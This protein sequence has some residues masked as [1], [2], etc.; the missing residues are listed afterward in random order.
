MAIIEDVISASDI[1]AMLTTGR[2]NFAIFHN[3]IKELRRLRHGEHPVRIPELYANTQGAIRNSIPWVTA[4][5]ITASLTA[6]FPSIHFEPVDIGDTHQS[7]ASKKERWTDAVLKRLQKEAGEKIFTQIMDNA[8]NDGLGIAK[9]TYMPSHWIG[10]AQA[11]TADGKFE[12]GKQDGNEVKITR[13][14]A[15]KL[16]KDGKEAKR[17]SKLP[18]SWRS[19]DPLNY[20]P[21]Y[22]EDGLAI[23]IEVTQ[24]PRMMMHK[25][26]R[27]DRRDED[28]PTGWAFTELQKPVDGEGPHADATVELIEFWTREFVAYLCDG[29]MRI[30][31]NPQERPPYFEIPGMMSAD[32]RPHRKYM[33]S[34]NGMRDIAPALDALLTMHKNLSYLQAYPKMVKTKALGAREE[35]AEVPI[36]GEEE[37]SDTDVRWI[38]GQVLDLSDEPGT[39]IS[40]RVPPDSPPLLEEIRQLQQMMRD[41]SPAE[42]FFGRSSGADEAGVAIS[43]RL[44]QSKLPLNWIATN[45]SEGISEM[46]EHMLWSLE[47]NVDDEVEVWGKGISKRGKNRDDLIS[48]GPKDVRGF[49]AN[50]VEMAPTMP[51]EQITEGQYA[52]GMR[53]AGLM[54]QRQALETR[55][56]KHPDETKRELMLEE[57]QNN[58]VVKQTIHMNAL[59]KGGFLPEPPS[60]GNEPGPNGANPAGRAGLGG[61]GLP[62]EQNVIPGTGKSAAS[63]TAQSGPAPGTGGVAPGE[64]ASATPQA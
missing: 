6:N 44:L 59:R 49:Y 28:N 15:D 13:E 33:S 3:R 61:A 64:V 51:F 43:Q 12:I 7:A 56:D 10:V 26:F 54:T 62:D 35:I 29:A 27:E 57:F 50:R 24:R 4:Q 19:V 1:S 11:L 34:L 40:Y 63:T 2:G 16:L 23:A 42:V 52:A 32:A 31:E 18:W 22:D 20:F 41:A 9:L 55:G 36:A 5:F 46:I 58:P 48:L 14:Y 17:K 25:K 60:S 8:A 37:G 38:A 30:I 53:S 45:A 47:N 21:F 39:D